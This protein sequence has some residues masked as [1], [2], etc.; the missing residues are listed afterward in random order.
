MSFLGLT[1]TI[2]NLPGAETL[3]KENV[4]KTVF[5]RVESAYE[6]PGGLHKMHIS[7]SEVQFI[8]YNPNNLLGAI[9]RL[10]PNNLLVKG[11]HFE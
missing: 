9:H 6:L 8:G 5:F 10:N 2:A 4:L 7:K 11:P 1:E 3:R